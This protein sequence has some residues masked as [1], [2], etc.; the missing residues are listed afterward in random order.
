VCGV[1]AFIAVAVLPTGAR[2]GQVLKLIGTLGLFVF[3]MTALLSSFQLWRM[4]AQVDRHQSPCGRLR[5]ICD[6]I[7]SPILRKR[8]TKLIADQEPHIEKLKRQKRRAAAHWIRVST[9]FLVGWYIAGGIVLGLIGP[10][11][12]WRSE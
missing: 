4:H 9:W 5:S 11:L 12:R 10:L 1:L 7:P 8:V 6:L 2:L 3:T